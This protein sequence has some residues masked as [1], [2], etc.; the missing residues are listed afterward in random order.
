MNIFK[1]A[2]PVTHDYT[3]RYWGHDYTFDPIDDGKKARMM[4]WG[5]GIKKGDYL[6]F[7]NGKGTTRYQ[8]KKIEYKRDPNDMWFAD[9]EFA[10]RN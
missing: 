8:V 9:V 3:K 7:Q 4:G 6:I 5:R 1:K 2:E 10:P